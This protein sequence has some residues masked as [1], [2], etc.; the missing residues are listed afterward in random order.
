M[1]VRPTLLIV[2]DE[3]S[4]RELITDLF[5]DDYQILQAADGTDA[6][7]ILESAGERVDVVLL[8]V[9]MPGLDGLE[10]L[11]ILR[12]N[13]QMAHLRVIMLSA[14]TDVD[15]KVK[16]F[17]A[18]AVDFINK[19]FDV[20]ELAAR[21][22]TQARLSRADAELKQA[23]RDAEAANRAKSEFLANM[24]H[25]I[26]T[27]LNAV[28]GSSEL[29]AMTTLDATQREYVNTIETSG[30][31]LLF[32]ISDILDYSKIE[33]GMLEL[34]A[35]RFA[36]ADCVE[37]AL[38]LV[39]NR[40]AAKRLRLTVESAPDLPCYVIGDDQR[41]RQIIVNLVSNAVKF[42]EQGRIN[43]A[44]TGH[45]ISHAVTG[46]AEGTTYQL[47]FE[48]TDTGIG[49]P[50]ERLSRLFKKFSQIDNSV[51]RRYGGTGLGL[52]ISQRLAELLGGG[53]EVESSGIPGQ[54]STF[55][56]RVVMPASL[57]QQSGHVSSP[58]IAVSDRMHTSGSQAISAIPDSLSGLS[59]LLAEDNPINQQVALKLLKSIGVEADLVRN[60]HEAVAAAS[61]KHYDVILMDVQM[62]ELDGIS[63]S[64]QIRQRLLTEPQPHI[65]ALTAN[66]TD[67]DRRAC[68][69]A[70]M[71]D[72]ATKPIRLSRLKDVL[73]KSCQIPAS[74]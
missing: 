10:V 35:I 50:P 14:R 57:D 5:K 3:Q 71:N 26:R 16:A 67:E 27:P 44:V 31:A 7:V 20:V 60:G 69:D 38:K 70:G 33:A 39:R 63:A 6:L 32:L 55:R 25:E 72:F 56:C 21:L 30:N 68:L 19:P 1:D 18:G 4:I 17:A 51:I 49:I 66:A 59:V 53:I 41:L 62:P 58:I 24:S 61:R 48:I 46:T 47:I 45:P 11:E 9:M 28:L 54:G 29:L 52:A 74:T 2:D 34:D 12:S 64:R 13:P 37:G 43:L 73:Q 23:K 22:N 65:I 15:N 40:A 42:T 8:D 36:L